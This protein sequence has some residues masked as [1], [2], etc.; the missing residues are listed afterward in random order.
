MVKR[1][2]TALPNQ[3]EA[4]NPTLS[5]KSCDAHSGTAHTFSA[6]NSRSSRDLERRVSDDHD[7]NVHHDPSSEPDCLPTQALQQ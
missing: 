3:R 7:D 6:N 5:G 4:G 2:M 1:D